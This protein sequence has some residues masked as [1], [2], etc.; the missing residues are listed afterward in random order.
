MQIEQLIHEKITSLSSGQ[1]KV[2]EYIL[3]HLDSF[4]YSTLAKLSKEISV[5][6]TTIIRLAYSLGFDSFS[7]MQRSVQNDILT[8]PQRAVD[9]NLQNGHFYQTIFARQ[10]KILESWATHIDQEQLDRIIKKLLDADQILLIGAR[11]SYS[12]ATW[13]GSILNQL[14]GN[15]HV[16]K[17]F[18]D[19]HFDYLTNI[20]DKTVVLCITFAR[21]TKW[22]YLY[23]QIAQKRG[24]HILAIT[25]SLTSPIWNLSEETIVVDANIDETGYNSFVCL[26]CL[27]DA[28]IAKLRKKKQHTISSRL[29]NLEELYSDFDL[30]FE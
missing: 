28:L 23:S 14:L 5:S 8:V 6:E 22:T 3:T 19:S 9:D 12:A 24:A 30:F 2:A 11:S 29:K 13:F 20:T 4:S 7:E 21:Y 17:E 1:R 10:I 26:Y 15:T 16:V 18:Y 25:D 27:F